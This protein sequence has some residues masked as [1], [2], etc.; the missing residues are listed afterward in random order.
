MFHR[1]S[2]HPEMFLTE[3]LTDRQPLNPYQWMDCGA[4]RGLVGSQD[5]RRGAAERP[6][7][8]LASPAENMPERKAARVAGAVKHFRTTGFGQGTGRPKLYG[9]YKVS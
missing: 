8:G 2:H 4:P 3:Y 9:L 6:V 7:E 5:D 1:P